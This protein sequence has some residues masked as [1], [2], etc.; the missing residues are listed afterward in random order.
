MPV[1]KSTP[2]C[3]CL[4][5]RYVRFEQRGDRFARDMAV[6]EVSVR[7]VGRDIARSTSF[8]TLIPLHLHKEVQ[9]TG[10]LPVI[11]GSFNPTCSRKSAD[12][13]GI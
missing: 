6:Y 13:Y 5:Y 7:V 8:V 3:R 10:R 11:L 9:V 2:K 1:P 12:A 4:E